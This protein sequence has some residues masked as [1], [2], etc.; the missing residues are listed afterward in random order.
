MLPLL[1]SDH[2][3]LNLNDFQCHLLAKL[4]IL[5][6]VILCEVGFHRL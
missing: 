2:A 6:L 5:A 4:Q 1:T 3:L